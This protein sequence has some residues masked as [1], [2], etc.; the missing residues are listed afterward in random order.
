MASLSPVHDLTARLDG[1]RSAVLA[2]RR[3]DGDFAYQFRVSYRHS[4]NHTRVCVC[5]TVCV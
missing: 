2:W 3:P 5:V 1:A 4:C